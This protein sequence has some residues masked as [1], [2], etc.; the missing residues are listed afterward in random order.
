MPAGTGVADKVRQDLYPYAPAG[1][2]TYMEPGQKLFG[3]KT[4]GG[5]FQ[6]ERQLKGILVSAGLPPK[7]PEAPA[8]APAP[9]RSFPIDLAALVTLGLAVAVATVLVMRRR[10]LAR[11]ARSPS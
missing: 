8:P 9:G 5:W 10:S 4:S 3:T 2:V 11:I 1:P 6:A 7:A